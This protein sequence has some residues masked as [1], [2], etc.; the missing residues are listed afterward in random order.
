MR[1]IPTDSKTITE[2]EAYNYL[3][4]IEPSHW[5]Y[6]GHN[7]FICNILGTLYEVKTSRE[8]IDYNITDPYKA[9][10]NKLYVINPVNALNAINAWDHGS[11][12]LRKTDDLCEPIIYINDG[13]IERNDLTF[14]VDQIVVGQWFTFI[15]K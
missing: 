11:T 1:N 9:F 15:K 6:D 4:N 7:K 5:L 12:I 10:T 14:T 8:L 3:K 13:K 2:I